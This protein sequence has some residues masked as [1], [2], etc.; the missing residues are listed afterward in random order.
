[1]KTSTRLIVHLQNPPKEDALK[2]LYTNLDADIVL[3]FGPDIPKPAELQ[4]LV[5]GRPEQAQIQTSPRLHSLVIPFA[6]LPATTRDLMRE[7]PDIAVYNLHHNAGLTAELGLALLFAAAKFL[8]PFDRE[9][10]QHNWSRRYLSN[11]SVALE[12]KTVLILGFGEIGKRIGRVCHALGM[13]VLAVRRRP[14]LPG[15]VDFPVDIYGIDALDRLLAQTHVLVV[16]LPA[17][18]ET[19]SMIGTERLR[20][21]PPGGIMVNVGRGAIV[22][23][24]ALYDALKDGHL[25]AAGLDVWY[26]YPRSEV[27]RANTPP[28]K[29]P[30]HEMENVVM[31]PH[32]GGQTRETETLRMQA[33]AGLI[34]DIARGDRV[35]NRVDVEAGY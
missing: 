32:R 26:N 11:P 9:L 13:R 27:E 35:P 15:G 7:F 16:A 29:L 14:E 6:G 33:L 23:Q 1:M 12:G 10:R 18:P 22:D 25:T 31:S 28:A 21:M 2:I 4:V 20:H 3:T 8:L 24:Q 17:T 19:D 30:F 5:T 34:N